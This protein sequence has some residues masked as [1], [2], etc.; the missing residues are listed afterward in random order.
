MGIL[1]IRSA[2]T[3]SVASIT[4]MLIAFTDDMELELATQTVL[5]LGAMAMQVG[6]ESGAGDSAG[7]AMR[8]RRLLVATSIT[9]TSLILKFARYANGK[10]W[11]VSGT[12]IINE[13]I[14][15]FL[16]MRFLNLGYGLVVT[17]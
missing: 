3:A 13:I 4:E 16:I 15:F 9:S 17:I 11:A 14:I 5:P 8:V 1:G 2:G 10:A 7:I 6:L 12:S